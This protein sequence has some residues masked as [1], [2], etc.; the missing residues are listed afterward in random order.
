MRPENR[1]DIRF[2][3]THIVDDEM[4]V[5][6]KILTR[7]DKLLRLAT[8]TSTTDG[9][10]AVAAVEAARL[11]RE[12]AL[13]I[14]E[15]VIKAK[16][17]KKYNKTENSPVSRTSAPATSTA[18]SPAPSSTWKSVVTL[19]NGNCGYCGKEFRSGDIVCVDTANGSMICRDWICIDG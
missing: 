10:R 9:E 7:V 4:P 13:V 11:I 17:K 6:Q 3:L 15:P 1:G 16:R 2:E 5:L 19:K 18:S 8:D 14:S 12:N